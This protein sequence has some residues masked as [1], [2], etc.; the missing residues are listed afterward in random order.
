MP[1]ACLSWYAL[2]ETEAA[3]DALW[4]VIGR[5]MRRAGI[6]A[7]EALAR[8]VAIPAV[9]CDPDL[10]LAQCC[11]YDIVYGFAASLSLLATPR[12]AAPG[13][14][15]SS[16]R[17]YVLVRD[18]NEARG[19]A[20]LRDG[21]CAINSFNSHSGAN[22]LRTLVAPFAAQGRFFAGVKV[23]GAHLESLALL[24]SGEADVM[25]MDCVL[26]ALLARYRPAALAGTR[27]LAASA[28]APAPPIVT[29]ASAGADRV[30]RIREALIAA[31]DDPASQA[32]REALLI[33]GVEVLP[34]RSYQR[35]VEIE[36]EA[37]GH[38]YFELHAT[39]L[40]LTKG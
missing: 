37:L 5:H 10:L 39:S 4:G 2:P 30:A 17:S 14:H 21:V 11:G 19:L 26:H 20:D 40:A 1:I 6:D 38:G 23:T 8:N 35:I 13:C 28:T 34:L 24:K 18:D 3:Q 27:I 15:E 9:F 32:A 29:S 16:Y 31:M 36:A 12:Y 22:V 7:P 33:D 25:A